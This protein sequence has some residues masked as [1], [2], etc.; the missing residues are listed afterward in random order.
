LPP[1]VRQQVVAEA[2]R[3]I[4]KGG[5]FILA[6][7]LRDGDDPNLDRMLEAFPIGFHEP[8]FTSW[9]KTDIVSLFEGAGFELV[10]T[11]QAFLTKA[12][13]FQKQ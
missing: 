10:D 9:L 2:G 12:F 5:V 1:K 3:V 7:A 11:R 8:F 6:D 13:A 4:K